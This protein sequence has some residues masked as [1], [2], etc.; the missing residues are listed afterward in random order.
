MNFWFLLTLV[1]PFSILTFSIIAYKYIGKKEI[2]KFDLVQF[3]YAFLFAP[4][5]FIWSKSFLFYLLRTDSFEQLGYGQVFFFDSLFSVFFL[6]VFAFI[7]IHSLTKSFQVKKKADPLYDLFSD[8]EFFHLFISHFV[9]YLGTMVLLT[10]FS[11]LNL[12]IPLDLDL[13][14]FWFSTMLFSSLM[15][16]IFCFIGIWLY[17]SIQKGALKIFKFLFGSFIFLHIICYFI[18]E[19][20]FDSQYLVFWVVFSIFLTMTYCSFFVGSNGRVSGRVKLR[21]LKLLKLK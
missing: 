8:S 4:V 5:I 17:A 20:S 10:V 15:I 11:I 1:V 19:P 6:Y 13:N 2:F 7:V 14:N 9:I 12:L 3:L 18:F 21:I 16:G